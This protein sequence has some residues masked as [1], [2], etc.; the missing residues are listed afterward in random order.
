MKTIKL[1]TVAAGFGVAVYLTAC[2]QA[3]TE[4]AGHEHAGH[5]AHETNGAAATKPGVKPYPLKVC[6]VSGEE[7]G[8]MGK[9]PSLVHNGQEIKFC[10]EDCIKDFN[11]DPAKFVAKLGK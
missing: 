4:P 5:A 7:L 11:A 3:P 1:I 8:K 6:L 10:C 9:I 2:S